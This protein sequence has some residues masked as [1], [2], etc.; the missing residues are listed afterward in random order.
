MGARRGSGASKALS[1]RQG[2]RQLPIDG[3]GDDPDL[4]EKLLEL[5]WIKGLSSIG[6]S[7]IRIL[8]DLHHQSIRPGG[9]SGSSHGRYFRPNTG[10]VARIR[11][12][13]EV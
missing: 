7:V 11:D 3:L 9:H 13:R 2:G 4:I 5:F 6:K 10:P 12:D 8:M 1:P